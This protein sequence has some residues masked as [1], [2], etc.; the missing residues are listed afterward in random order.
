MKAINFGAFKYLLE[1]KNTY[2]NFVQVCLNRVFY[3]YDALEY[4]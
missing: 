1:I 3:R 4:K 2:R